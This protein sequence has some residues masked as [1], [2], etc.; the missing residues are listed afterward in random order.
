ME[1]LNSTEF[2]LNLL[3][4]IFD[5]QIL[6]EAALSGCRKTD[7][8]RCTKFVKEAALSSCRKTDRLSC[9]KFGCEGKQ[10][11]PGVETDRLSC[12]KFGCEG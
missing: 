10:H 6:K 2:N 12:T 11:C 3:R 7:R 1:L 8:L 9:T 5:T 4:T